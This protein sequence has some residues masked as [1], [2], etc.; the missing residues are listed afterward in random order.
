MI[1]S[2]IWDKLI[3]REFVVFEKFTSAY[4]SQIARE[5]SCDYLLIIFMKKLRESNTRNSG[6]KIIYSNSAKTSPRLQSKQGQSPSNVQVTH[7][8]NRKIWLNGST[9]CLN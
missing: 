3:V 6:R 4:F 2:A 8:L 1:S 9:N 7:V 5:K